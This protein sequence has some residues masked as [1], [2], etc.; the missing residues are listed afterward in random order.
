LRLDGGGGEKN[1]SIS[2]TKKIYW[3][4]F[5]TSSNWK[6]RKRPIDSHFRGKMEKPGSAPE[7]AFKA[8]KDANNPP[9]DILKG[10]LG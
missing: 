8:E 6:G 2:L 5:R 1:D 10:T 3:G 7:K 4:A 9:A